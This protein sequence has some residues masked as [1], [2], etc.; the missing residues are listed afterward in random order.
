MNALTAFSALWKN[1]GCHGDGTSCFKELRQLWTAPE[2]AYHNWRHLTECRFELHRVKAQFSQCNLMAVEMALWF[3]DAIYD[4]QKNDNEERS[5]DLATATL[6][7]GRA[8]EAFIA[9]VAALIMATKNHQASG[10]DPETS[11]MLDID[12]S[13]LGKP[14][15]SYYQYEEGIRAEYD[16]VPP[17]IFREKRAEI[18]KGFLR[19]ERLY[20]TEPFF[21]AYEPQARRN[22]AKAIECLAK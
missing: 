19:R 8:K 4:S 13:I 15:E 3:H 6:K 20:L 17:E 11:L 16:W 10:S 5:A 7:D 12:L 18:L 21:A 2:R 14:P 9:K 1:C 22:L